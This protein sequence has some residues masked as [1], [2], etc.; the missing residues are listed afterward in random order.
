MAHSQ[1][2]PV[3]PHLCSSLA[4][5]HSD[6]QTLGYPIALPTIVAAPCRAVIHLRPASSH[7][8]PLPLLTLK[9]IPTTG[10]RFCVVLC[11]QCS[12]SHYSLPPPSTLTLFS[13]TAVCPQVPHCCRLLLPSVNTIHHC[14]PSLLT[15]IHADFIPGCYKLW[16]SQH[17]GFSHSKLLSHFCH[18]S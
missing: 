10:V 2:H 11:C 16:D 14:R 18:S 9:L 5:K 3:H 13:A 8:S 1:N 4:F 17:V 7:H 12:L 6:V 15:A